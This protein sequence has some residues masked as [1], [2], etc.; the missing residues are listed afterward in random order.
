VFF[1]F[2]F[3]AFSFLFFYFFFFFFLIFSRIPGARLPSGHP[4]SRH[5]HHVVGGGD[6]GEVQVHTIQTPESG[7]AHPSDRLHPAKD[8][9][10]TSA[11][12]NAHGVPAWRVVRPS[13]AE[14]LR[15]R[16][17]CGVTFRSRKS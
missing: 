17:I 8:R 15:L 7:F 11:N 14:P 9:L 5:T 4:Q 10:D 1:T 3:S 6:Q 13:M 2:F 16:A 12:M